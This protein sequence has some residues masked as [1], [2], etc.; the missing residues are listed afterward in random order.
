MVFRNEFRRVPEVIVS[1]ESTIPG[2]YPR[3]ATVPLCDPQQA[4]HQIPFIIDLG[5][6]GFNPCIFQFHGRLLMAWRKGWSPGRIWIG[7]LDSDFR[8]ISSRQLQLTGVDGNP[9]DGFEDPRFLV[10]GGKLWIVFSWV[11]GGRSRQSFARL[12]PNLRIDEHFYIDR[13]TGRH[14]KNW[15]FFS[16]DGTIRAVYSILPH[17]I[18]CFDGDEYGFTHATEPPLHWNWGQPRGG[19][20]PVRVGDEF[21]SFFHS[22]RNWN[23]VAGFYAFSAFPPYQITRWPSDPCLVARRDIWRTWG[24]AVV[25]PIGALFD[26]GIWLVSYGWH[27][28]HC[29]LAAF[30]H[31][32]L[33]AQLN[34]VVGDSVYE[35]PID[36]AT[37]QPFVRQS[38]WRTRYISAERFSVIIQVT[39]FGE[40]LNQLR[41]CLSAV[42]RCYPDSPLIVV[43]DGIDQPEYAMVAGEF[44]ARFVFGE[45]LK[46]CSKGALFFDRFFREALIETGDLIFKI[47]V[48]THFWRPLRE[49]PDSHFF[50][51]LCDPESDNEH[52][53][54][55]CMVFS[56]EFAEKA[57]SSGVLLNEEFQSPENWLLG[58]ASREW[59]RRQPDDFLAE[60]CLA[61]HL[62]RRLGLSWHHCPE[63]Y[64]H[65][66]V[67]P[68]AEDYAITHP[69]VPCGS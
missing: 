35:M 54:S 58:K 37:H 65:S 53:Q 38:V 32:D 64:S 19:T 9:N 30:R 36:P 41:A 4:E 21:F 47:D 18:G 69:W 60:D 6:E 1:G 50:G 8:V 45:R 31:S 39:V 22:S 49:V 7:E 11:R 16:T 34:V 29:C 12:D 33:L 57:V 44:G 20:P 68:A 23:Y 66:H 24:P 10:G 67:P 40:P 3:L 42:R 13:P 59:L 17:T 62:A 48:D 14:E 56:R 61:I 51:T 26:D 46:I 15:Q 55:G 28:T 25:F 27:D 2:A 52:T 43:S 63:I 5:H